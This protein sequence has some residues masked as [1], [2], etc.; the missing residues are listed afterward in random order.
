MRSETIYYLIN[1]IDFNI[2]AF[3]DVDDKYSKDETYDPDS[4]LSEY[5]EDMKTKFEAETFTRQIETNLIDT[6]KPKCDGE[7]NPPVNPKFN[8]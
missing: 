7:C 6:Y 1:K 3:M 5:D 2:D 8:N 4:W